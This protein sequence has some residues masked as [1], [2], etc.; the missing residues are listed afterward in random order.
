MA[1]MSGNEAPTG[2]ATRTMGRY[3]LVRPLGRGGMAEVFLARR[4]GPGGVEKRLVVKR[5]RRERATDPRFHDLFV[6]EAR[7]SMSFAH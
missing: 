2:R 3:E 4:R 6:Q 1:R 5:I 7:T